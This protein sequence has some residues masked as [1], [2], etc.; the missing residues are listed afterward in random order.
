MQTK[1]G[2]LARTPWG[3]PKTYYEALKGKFIL[4]ISK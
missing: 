1:S 3:L 2:F 4:S